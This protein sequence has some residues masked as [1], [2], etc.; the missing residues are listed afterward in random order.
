VGQDA[1][2]SRALSSFPGEFIE[3]VNDSSENVGRDAILAHKYSSFQGEF[4]ELVKVSLIEG[5][6]SELNYQFGVQWHRV[7]SRSRQIGVR[8]FIGI[9]LDQPGQFFRCSYRE[10]FIGRRSEPW[11]RLIGVI[12][13]AAIVQIDEIEAGRIQVTITTMRSL[14]DIPGNR[15]L[16]TRQKE[17]A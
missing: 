6:N 7:V 5:L 10:E 1:I 11:S 16:K 13:S 14:S 17:K 3:L 12:C 15:V 2:L 8:A 9:E 4:N